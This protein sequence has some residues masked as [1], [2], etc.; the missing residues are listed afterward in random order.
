MRSKLARILI[1]S[2]I[3]A[4]CGGSQPKPQVVDMPA[5][6]V[7]AR[8][9]EPAAPPS[10]NDPVSP[11]DPKIKRG[12]LPNGLTYYVV[13]HHKP[14]QRAALWLAVN[15]GSVQE[16]DDQRG[17][18][19]YVEHMAFNG[20]KRFPKQEI[21]D[22]IEKS[23]MR[24]G[25]DA[26]A[27]TSFDQTVYQLT[28]PT[29][30]QAIMLKGLD[31][32]RDWSNDVTFDPAEVE[33]ERGVVLEEWRLGRGADARIFDKQFP[34]IFQGSKYGTRLPIGIPE[35]LKKAPRDTLV[36]Y[37]KDWYQPQNMAVIAVGDFDEVQ[38]E[39]EIQ[40]RF[41]DLKRTANAKSRLPVP[42]P[43]DHPTL[44]T[45]ETDLEMPYTSV[46]VYDKMDHRRE[47][48]KGDYRRFIVEAL[49]HQMLNARF[50]ELAQDPESPFMYAGSGTG[51][52]ARTS[53][54]F[55]RYA[56]VKEGR[57]EETVTALFREIVRVEKYGFLP[58][59][60][61]RAAKDQL[62][63][64]ETSA[65][66]WE[67]TPSAALADEITRHFFEDEQMPGRH[68]EL[69]FNR[70]LIP[71]VT[72]DELNHL[73]RTWGGEKGRVIAISAPAKSTVPTIADVKKLVATATAANVDPWKDDA[74]DKPL[75]APKPAP[76][77][78]TKTAVD[79]ANGVTTWTLANGI[80]V[81]I[82]PTTYQND[83]IVFTAFERGGHSLVS[84]KDF[85]H[86]RFAAEIVSSSGVG[87]FDATALRK[88]LAGKEA[89]ASVGISE[90]S[91][92]VSGSARPADI[93]TAL[94]LAHLRI[95]APRKDPKA[96]AR[97]R[98]QQLEDVRNKSLDPERV[99]F[100][101]MSEITSSKHP[102]YAPETEKMVNA[103]DHD[104][105]LAI[106]KERF[107]DAGDFTFVFVGN[108]EP[109]TLQ[110]L[111]ETYLGSL[112]SKGRKQKWKDIGVKFPAKKLTTTV[113]LG[114]E[115][116][117]FFDLSMNAPDK[118]SL[119]GARDANILSMVLRIRLREVLREDMGGVYGVQ[120][121]ASLQREPKQKRDLG[122]FFGCAPEN[123]EKLRTAVFDEVA[124]VAK[125][126][127]GPAY[128]DKVKETMRRTRETDSKT[129]WWW[130]SQ[131]RQAAY[132][133]D[134][135]GKAIDMSA[136]LARVTSDNIKKS[137]S[138][139]FSKDTYVLGIMRPAAPPAPAK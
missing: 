121:W 104:K 96:F 16:D 71:T 38:I 89:R 83:E 136:T 67:K 48:T 114:S 8:P 41:G 80:K 125:D 68:M 135:L 64:A 25:A 76:G 137:A 116:K 107:S 111:V 14:E 115:P 13:K 7:T 36:R 33:K 130:M 73:A 28:V 110:P 5:E 27:Y 95:T 113:N 70:E 63:G 75:M 23:G 4:G 100:E 44:V 102:R 139:F 112:P 29:D 61:A 94:Q 34:I 91:Q 51:G 19:H 87:E 101:T 20:T 66:E 60:L 56:G 35:V 120:I 86:A 52:F 78:V 39:K 127:I 12:T 57:V 17:L 134:D 98:A 24:F 2:F 42:V 138:R 117:S 31:I 10:P 37:Y 132:Y 85:V 49:Y 55:S 40:A 92:S 3:A 129:N 103:V 9:A 79:E 99:F 53:D 82:K 50:A 32:L 123:V 122:V 108:I 133:G 18:A 118:W 93:E 81:L 131:I 74:G 21:V 62:T 124:K 59:E 119:D 45:I 47:T 46:S 30:D 84:D 65:A 6:V 97:W 88:V 90:L 77:K 109:A 72:L 26:N 54:T 105:A 69:A 128:L 22:F 43:H 1:T 58:S 15:A 106:F 11:L 126:G